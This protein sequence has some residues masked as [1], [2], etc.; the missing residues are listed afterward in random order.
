MA[1]LKTPLQAGKEYC[2]SFYASP[3]EV[4][5]F[6]Y[7]SFMYAAKELGA[8]IS[9]NSTAA[10]DSVTQ[11]KYAPALPYTPQIAAT[12][13]MSDISRWH[14]ISGTYTAEG[15]EQWITIGNFKDDIQT[16]GS[17]LI[18]S[19]LPEAYLK[20]K[21]YYFIDKVSVFSIEEVKILPE[22][23]SVCVNQFPVSITAKPDLAYY[24][25]STGDTLMQI[26]ATTKG[27]YTLESSLEGCA[28]RDTIQLQAV[29][30]L[31]LDLG[32]DVDNC[33]DGIEQTVQLENTV[34]LDNYTW[35]TGAHTEQ[36]AVSQT[37]VYRLT[38]DHICGTF[39]DE[40]HVSGCEPVL[41]VPNVFA[42]GVAGVNGYFLPYGENV[43][44]EHLRV[45]NNWGILLYKEDYPV[46]GWDGTFNNRPC[47]PG[48]YVWRLTYRTYNNPTELN[49]YGDITLIR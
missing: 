33:V 32:P 17:V 31:T 47:P 3:A 48:V 23:F 34:P 30:P 12:T 43:Q 18:S 49:K 5:E 37:G 26:N 45:Y 16:K 41:Y 4:M 38:T 2:V 36:I 35:S 1:K 46:R 15:G 10:Y 29:Q 9:K 11:P 28:V 20:F 8:Y 42:P 14:R 27:T 24:H 19:G 6:N 13:V 39:S 7:A 22:D 44:L 21:S 25:W 40:V